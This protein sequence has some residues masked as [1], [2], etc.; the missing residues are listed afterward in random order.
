[1]MKSSQILP[2]DEADD[3]DDDEKFEDLMKDFKADYG[4]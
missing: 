1:M 3:D 4:S 2:F